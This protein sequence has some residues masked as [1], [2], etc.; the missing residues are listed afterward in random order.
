MEK[1][2]EEKKGD[3]RNQTVVHLHV[4]L[5]VVFRHIDGILEASNLE[6]RLNDLNVRTRLGRD[7]LRGKFDV[8]LLHLCAYSRI[9]S[10]EVHRS[11][12]LGGVSKSAST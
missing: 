5:R 12:E 9:Q 1:A 11:L 7:I 6:V 3:A 10:D 2:N 8:F 4:T